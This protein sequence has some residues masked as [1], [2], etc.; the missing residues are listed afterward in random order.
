MQLALAPLQT[1]TDHHYRNAHHLVYGGIDTYYAPY[2]RMNNDGTIKAG[3][4][5]D[6]LPENNLVPI[7]PQLMCCSV[8]DFFMLHDYIVSLGYN[9]VNWNMGCPYPMVTNKGLGAGVLNKPEVLRNWLEAI[10][11]KL[12]LKL[13]IKM[14]MGMSNTEEIHTLIPILNDYDLTEV[15]IHAR[16]AE[17]LYNGGCDIDQFK[18]AAGSIKHPVTYN[19]DI[20]DL[21]SFHELSS[22]LNA[23][24]RFMIG[25]GAISNPA[26]FQ[27]I[28][29]GILLDPVTYRS[30][31]LTFSRHIEE[32]CMKVNDNEGYA[33]MRLKSYWEAFSEEL[34]EGKAVY[35]K[36]KK[37]TNL[38]EFWDLL[39]RGIVY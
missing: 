36:L 17:Q 6:I 29:T 13:G 1:Y 3:P 15:I 37:A 21:D 4:K 28:K 35:R 8:E 23:M 12:K 22:E 33:L 34:T 7:V 24:D 10:S 26:I 18:L 38:N 5:V 11:P 9:E 30:K 19:G 2:L 31:L 39:N 25:R 14:R 16:Y 32:S 27:E 20:T